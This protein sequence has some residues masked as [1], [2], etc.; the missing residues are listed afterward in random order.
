[1]VKRVDNAVYDAVREVLDGQFKGGFHTFGLD[2][3]GVAY[4][5]DRHNQNLI[6]EDILKRVEEAKGKI[7]GGEIKVTDAMAP[8]KND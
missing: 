5:M 3:D 1:M 7:V 6:P 2:K 8:K 4:S